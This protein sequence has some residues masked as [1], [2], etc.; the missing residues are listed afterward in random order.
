MCSTPEL[1]SERLP[2][3]KAGIE[4][5]KD[6]VEA[7]AVQAIL[8]TLTGASTTLRVG[9][10]SPLRP[11][12]K[13]RPAVRERRDDRRQVVDVARENRF[14]HCNGDRYDVAIDDVCCS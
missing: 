7:I 14:G 3:I 9:C 10:N 1:A 12:V 4:N 11:A 2:A 13:S 8:P 5:V 6:P